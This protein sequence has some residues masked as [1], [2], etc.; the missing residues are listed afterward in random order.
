[1]HTQWR[2]NKNQSKVKKQKADRNQ[3]KKKMRTYDVIRLE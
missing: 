1:M 3:K 2:Q